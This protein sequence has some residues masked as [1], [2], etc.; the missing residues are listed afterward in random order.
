MAPLLLSV[1]F[2]LFTTVMIRML[3]TNKAQVKLKASKGG[4]R[5]VIGLM[6]DVITLPWGLSG[7]DSANIIRPQTAVSTRRYQLPF[8]ALH[9][10]TNITHLF[11]VC[12]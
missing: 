1:G 3:G 2:C 10:H 6:T 11:H 12:F 5:A 9:T 7:L 8:A 4:V